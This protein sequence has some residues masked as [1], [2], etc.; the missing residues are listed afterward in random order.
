MESND[1]IESRRPK[2]LRKTPREK[3]V[4]ACM[5]ANPKPVPRQKKFVR[6][7]GMTLEEF[8]EFFGMGKNASKV[9][10][11]IQVGRKFE[12]LKKTPSEK[13]I[14]A[15]MKKN[16]KPEKKVIQKPEKKKIRGMS[17]GALCAF[18]NLPRKV[19]LPDKV[20]EQKDLRY[21]THLQVLQQ[22]GLMDKKRNL[23]LL[24]KFKGDLQSVVHALFE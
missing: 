16:K 23:E 15:C 1:T 21:K 7:K 6:N 14:L 5:R 3:F 2:M 9:S 8:T 22:M 10:K 13:F 4:L 24:K 12:Y 20:M 11:G 17:F 18:L 19:V